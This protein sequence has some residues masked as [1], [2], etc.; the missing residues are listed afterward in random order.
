MTRPFSDDCDLCEAARITPWYHEDDICWIAE[1]EICAVPM[2]V[3]RGHGTEPPEVELAHMHVQLATVVIGGQKAILEIYR[4]DAAIRGTAAP[5]VEALDGLAEALD[6]VS[7]ATAVELEVGAHA[8]LSAGVAVIADRFDRAAQG[9]VLEA[10]GAPVADQALLLVHRG[11]AAQ[12]QRDHC[13]QYRLAVCHASTSCRA[14]MAASGVL[15]QS[16][17]RPSRIP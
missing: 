3:W 13:G 11:T 2:V 1:C 9:A 4:A 7:V 16:K 8:M 17:R 12:Y 14:R 15:E 10:N 6:T 5:I